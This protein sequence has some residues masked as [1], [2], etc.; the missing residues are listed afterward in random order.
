MC[1]SDLAS[2]LARFVAEAESRTGSFDRAYLE[3]LDWMLDDFDLDGDE[4][5]ALTLLAHRAGATTSDVAELHERY[6]DAFIAA[7]RRD[8][9]ISDLEHATLRRLA[10]LLDIPASRVPEIT[11]LPGIDGIASGMLVCF[12]DTAVG[13]DGSPRSRD[14]LERIARGRGLEPVRSEEHTSELQSH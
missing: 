12:T 3:T 4:W 13:P 2:V 5:G 9:V 8:G 11:E 10:S 1:S 14:D 6:L 7:S